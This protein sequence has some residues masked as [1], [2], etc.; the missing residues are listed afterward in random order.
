[1][2]ILIVISLILTGCTVS[3][4]VIRT[5]GQATDLVDENQS[6]S[7]TVNPNISIPTSLI[8]R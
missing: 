1:M 7:T 2:N 4:N 3:V 6:P 5:Q 8:P